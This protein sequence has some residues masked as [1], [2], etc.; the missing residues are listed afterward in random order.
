MTNNMFKLNFIP[1]SYSFFYVYEVLLLIHEIP[2]HPE[3]KKW[4]KCSLQIE[5][6]VYAIYVK[7]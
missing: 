3:I 6:R 7:I 4:A 2:G 1:L 5:I